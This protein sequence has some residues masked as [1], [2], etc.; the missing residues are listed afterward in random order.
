MLQLK[1]PFKVAI[2][3][4]C[5]TVSDMDIEKEQEDNKIQFLEDTFLGI[6]VSKVVEEMNRLDSNKK[7]SKDK[8]NR[9]LIGLIKATNNHKHIEK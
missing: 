9:I 2:N 7:P 1:K 4:M 3:I 6:P 5:E 8:C